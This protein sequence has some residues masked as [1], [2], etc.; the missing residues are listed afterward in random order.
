MPVNFTDRYV[1]KYDLVATQAAR[2]N[3]NYVSFFSFQGSVLF[4]DDK[5]RGKE[6]K[7][8]LF[9]FDKVLVNAR[10]KECGKKYICK[11]AMKVRTMHFPNPT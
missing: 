5:P 1:D 8:E 2:Y 3:V 9:L 10:T 7:R 11:F 4:W 6:K